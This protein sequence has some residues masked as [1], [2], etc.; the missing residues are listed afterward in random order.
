MIGSQIEEG[1]YIDTNG[2][3]VGRHK[4]YQLYTVGQ[5]KGLGLNIGHPNFV[6]EI[7]PETNDVVVGEFEKLLIDRVEVTN[8]KFH[9]NIEEIINTELIARPR[10]SSRGLK[11]KLKRNMNDQRLCFIFN[12]RNAENSN[13]QHIVFY[14]ENE[15]IGGGE[16]SIS[17]NND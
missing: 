11:G 9:V 3:I 10:F 2:N 4:G 7:R 1:N 16:I 8:E 12:E 6:L 14:K 5:R 17:T 13:G 15:L